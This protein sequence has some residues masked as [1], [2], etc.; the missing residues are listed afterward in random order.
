MKK[1]LVFSVVVA[2]MACFVA[3]S[4][5]GS[6]PEAVVEKAISAIQKGNYDA[7]AATYD[8]SESDQKMLSGL[9]EEKISKSLE[10]KG[11]IKSFK[12]TDTKIDGE[13]A[14]V[15]V[16][17]VYKNGSEDDETMKLK[18]VDGAWKQVMSK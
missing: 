18:K 7:F 10:E 6:G 15:K 5:S 2:A 9:A 11:G 12:I 13:E 4:S 1:I 8:L 16:H 3:C 17:F 14:T